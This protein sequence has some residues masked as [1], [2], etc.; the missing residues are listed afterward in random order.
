[1]TAHSEHEH[2]RAV[3]EEVRR[4]SRAGLNYTPRD[5]AGYTATL[6]EALVD[7]TV[8]VVGLH[9]A[10]TGWIRS[11]PNWPAVA[12]LLDLAGPAESDAIVARD[13]QRWRAALRTHRVAPLSPDLPPEQEPLLVHHRHDA[14]A[15]EVGGWSRLFGG[16]VRREDIHDA[17]DAVCQRTPM[18]PES[19]GT[20]CA[21]LAADLRA[22]YRGH[23]GRRPVTSSTAWRLG[24]PP[25]KRW[26]L[27]VV[28]DAH[29]QPYPGRSVAEMG[30]ER[31]RARLSERRQWAATQAVGGWQRAREL[32]E[33]EGEIQRLWAAW[34]AAYLRAAA[35]DGVELDDEPLSTAALLAGPV[36]EPDR[37]A[38]PTPEQWERIQARIEAMR[39]KP[40]GAGW[41]AALAGL[42]EVGR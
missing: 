25:S 23:A 39:A 8:S 37:D 21:T 9:N 22:L 34:R 35:R 40:G 36:G 3:T 24:W 1:M 19:R 15:R 7:S 41:G 4:L 6:T 27:H 30:A 26:T 28:A 10:V 16:L 12:E 14:V 18:P 17:I 38:R 32:A 20:W 29:L 31:T 33:Q 2:A 42:A 11:R 13:W 5:I